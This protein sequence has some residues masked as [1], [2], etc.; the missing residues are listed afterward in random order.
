MVGECWGEVSVCLEVENQKAAFGSI[1]VCIQIVTG[2]LT[3]KNE[4]KPEA[5]F[6]KGSA[7]ELQDAAGSSSAW[8]MDVTGLCEKGSQMPVA[9]WVLALAGRVQLETLAGIVRRL[10]E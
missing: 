5:Q 8:M 2:L 10:N 1:A 6:D 7:G 4:Q 9:L 3:L